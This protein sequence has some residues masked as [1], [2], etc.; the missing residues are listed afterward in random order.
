MTDRKR[1]LDI[2]QP[3]GSKKSQKDL[4]PYTFKPFSQRY[5]DILEKRHTLPVYEYRVCI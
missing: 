5:Y 2:E 4:N 3:A 1:R